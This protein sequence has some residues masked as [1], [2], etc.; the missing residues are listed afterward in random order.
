MRRTVVLRA[1]KDYEEGGGGHDE[2]SL[3]W[4]WTKWKGEDL[5]CSE[6]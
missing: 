2:F 6:A 5:G 4:A 3:P 1:G